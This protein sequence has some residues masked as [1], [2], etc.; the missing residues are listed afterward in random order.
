MLW[1][2]EVQMQRLI[3]CFLFSKTGC[4]RRKL[5]FFA[6][7][8][9][10]KLTAGRPPKTCL[11]RASHYP[12]SPPLSSSL[13][14]GSVI[15]EQFGK[16]RQLNPVMGL[17]S[18]SRLSDTDCNWVLLRAID[19]SNCASKQITNVSFKA[20]LESVVKQCNI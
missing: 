8:L 10:T 3:R 5:S 6:A 18:P 1:T 14:A 12:W 19:F 13:S 9:N 20:Q 17:V 15:H 16:A 11:A 7:D 4:K 2:F